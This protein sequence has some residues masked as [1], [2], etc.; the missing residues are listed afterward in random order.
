MKNLDFI[1]GIF[2]LSFKEVLI[3]VLVLLSIAAPFLVKDVILSFSDKNKKLSIQ[4]KNLEKENEWYSYVEDILLEYHENIEKIKSINE[5]DLFWFQEEIESLIPVWIQLSESH[6]KKDKLSIK[7]TAPNLRTIDFLL[8]ILNNFNDNYWGFIWEVS[9]ENVSKNGTLFSFSIK[10][11]IDSEKILSK[12]YSWD[13]DW[14]GVEDSVIEE[15]ISSSWV[16]QKKS[17]INDQC[18]FTPSFNIVIG[19]LIDQNIKLLDTFP[20]YREQYDKGYFNFNKE[21]WCL[22]NWDTR[23]STE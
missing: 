22:E 9:S 23:I 20:Y 7:W 8:V 19:N 12:V 5:P 2:R 18:P 16:K 14:D 3:L 6:I 21:T 11:E 1:L 10:W 4:K 17:I 13:F 15:V